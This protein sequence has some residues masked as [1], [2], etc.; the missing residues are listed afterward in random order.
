MGLDEFELHE[1]QRGDKSL[2][3]PLRGTVTSVLPEK[4]LYKIEGFGSGGD[5]HYAIRHP[6]LGV[7]SWIRAVGEPGTSVLIQR[8]GDI[9]QQEIWGYISN[10]V[11]SIINLSLR[12]QKI[13]Y[14]VLQTG[15]VEIMSSGKAADFYSRYGDLEMYGGSLR[16]ALRQTEAE[17]FSAAPTYNRTWWLNKPNALMHQEKIGVVKR[18]NPKWPYTKHEPVKNSKDEYLVEHSFWLNDSNDQPLSEFQEG[19]VVDELGKIIKQGSTNKDLRLKKTMYASAGGTLGF[20]IDEELNSLWLNTSQAKE[21]KVNF[22]AKN[23]VTWQAKKWTVKVTDTGKLSFTRSLSITSQKIQVNCD[24]VTFGA[25]GSQKALL[26][27]MF[28]NSI[29]TPLFVG[30]MAV[31]NTVAN[32]PASSQVHKGASAAFAQIITVLQQVLQ[33]T[34]SKAIKFST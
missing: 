29:M 26:G 34:L 25:S 19:H 4:E 8:R 6:F 17:I 2:D 13:A 5:P 27:D 16:L 23:E 1:R 22:G 3:L 11:E 9:K 20:E 15:E 28:I 12:D 21:T 7:N 14:R 30:L 33:Q 32:D 31:H 24:D 10:K 18:A